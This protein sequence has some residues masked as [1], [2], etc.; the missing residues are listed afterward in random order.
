M[1]LHTMCAHAGVCVC[2]SENGI[3][4]ISIKKT[5]YVHNSFTSMVN[6]LYLK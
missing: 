3:C 1:I 6:S 4:Q 5:L 2:V